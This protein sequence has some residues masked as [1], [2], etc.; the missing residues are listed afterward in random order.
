VVDVTALV[1]HPRRRSYLHV[2]PGD[3]GRHAGGARSPYHLNGWHLS[4]LASSC[5]PRRRDPADH[6]DSPAGECMRARCQSRGGHQRDIRFQTGRR[7][8]R[9]SADGP[10]RARDNPPRMRLESVLQAACIDCRYSEVPSLAPGSGSYPRA[11]PHC[12]SVSG[13][14][15]CRVET[16]LVARVFQANVVQQDTEDIRSALAQKA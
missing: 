12:C 15:I 8:V 13:L 1:R 7:P 4:A 14:V 16:V 11:D 9:P 10:R 2:R 6:P 5:S 3:R